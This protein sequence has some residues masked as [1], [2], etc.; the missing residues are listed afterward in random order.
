MSI[1]PFA[2]SI[3]L[4]IDPRW[5]RRSRDAS[6]FEK[7]RI[8][9]LDKFRG[10]SPCL[11]RAAIFRV[12]FSRE[13]SQEA[14]ILFSKFLPRCNRVRARASRSAMEERNV[15]L[16]SP[17][18]SCRVTG[19]SLLPQLDL[20]DNQPAINPWRFQLPKP[21]RRKASDFSASGRLFRGNRKTKNSTDPLELM[22]LSRC[23]SNRDWGSNIGKADIIS[24]TPITVVSR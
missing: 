20:V 24:V 11:P 4:T 8:G 17:L 2:Q 6:L 15:R 14:K 16:L 23:A 3:N 5:E 9:S 13:R 22:D 7:R 1:N 10:G 19:R 12:H 18:P 21:L